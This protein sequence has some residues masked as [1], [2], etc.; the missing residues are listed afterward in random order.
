LKGQV[1]KEIQ[2]VCSLFCI[3]ICLMTLQLTDTAFWDVDM[4]TLDEKKH[5]DFIIIR[6]FQY[7]LLNDLRLV[8]KNYDKATIKQAFKSSRAV[9][10]KAV[11]LAAI[12]LNIPENELQ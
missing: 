2:K 5:G 1:S 3:Y 4:N 7:G 11:A 12:T 10:K 6:V 8:L 9:D